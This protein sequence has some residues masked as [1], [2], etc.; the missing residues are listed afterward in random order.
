MNC[1]ISVCTVMCYTLI[2][3][4]QR[5]L[6]VSLR[7]RP[8]YID[9]YS[10]LTNVSKNNLNGEIIAN[11]EIFLKKKKISHRTQFLSTLLNSSRDY[12]RFSLKT[13]S[14]K[15]SSRS[16]WYENNGFSVVRAVPIRENTCAFLETRHFLVARESRGA[17][18]SRFCLCSTDEDP[19]FDWKLMIAERRR[20]DGRKICGLLLGEESRSNW[21]RLLATSIACVCTYVRGDRFTREIGAFEA[22]LTK[23]V[24]LDR[25]LGRTLRHSG[26]SIRNSLD[27]CSL[28]KHFLPRIVDLLKRISKGNGWE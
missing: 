2:N 15:R 8:F 21:P 23:P 22:A 3:Y 17:S 27:N 19:A 16:S 20:R 5:N 14:C 6:K 4:F 18:S 11:I 24:S 12:T 9:P 10:K 26:R 28:S 1:S 13:H 25:P 7:I